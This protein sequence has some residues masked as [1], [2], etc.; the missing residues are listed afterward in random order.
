MEA[1]GQAVVRRVGLTPSLTP[2]FIPRQE[3]LVPSTGA[4]VGLVTT[5]QGAAPNK[6]PEK[7]EGAAQ[8]V[9]RSQ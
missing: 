6:Q 5:D 8:R 2:S 4:A 1:E 3:Q 9:V 7:K